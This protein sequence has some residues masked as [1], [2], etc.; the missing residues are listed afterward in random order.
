VA[1]FLSEGRKTF[2]AYGEER[3]LPMG[4]KCVVLDNLTAREVEMADSFV[5]NF[6]RCVLGGNVLDHLKGAA[7][8]LVEAAE[9]W[10][11][12]GKTDE[13]FM[14]EVGDAIHHLEGV[15][16]LMNENGIVGRAMD[17]HYDKNAARGYYGM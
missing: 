1:D 9:A 4:G 10:H 13:E 15:V 2:L 5:F 7:A 17:T 3:E 8:E 16:R 6:P 14:T 11:D 12:P